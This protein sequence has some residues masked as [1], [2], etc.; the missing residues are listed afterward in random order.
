MTGLAVLVYIVLDHLVVNLEIFVFN[1]LEG[2]WFI[3][4][5][6][7]GVNGVRHLLALISHVI[8]QVSVTKASLHTGHVLLLLLHDLIRAVF[9]GMSHLEL[10]HILVAAVLHKV[11]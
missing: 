6:S 9:H 11:F 4:L 7:F 10:V 8:I 1:I 2:R 5:V 3:R